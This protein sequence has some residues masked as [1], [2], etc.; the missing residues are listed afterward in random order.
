MDSKPYK[1]VI[2]MKEI[3]IKGKRE[4]ITMAEW[5]DIKHIVEADLIKYKEFYK[6]LAEL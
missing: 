3:K 5:K 1:E 2:K 4:P 6:Q